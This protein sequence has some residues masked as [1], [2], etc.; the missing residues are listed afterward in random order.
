[1]DEIRQLIEGARQKLMA[2]EAKKPPLQL[3]ACLSCA[4]TF[5]ER[6]LRECD[7]PTLV[8]RD[9]ILAHYHD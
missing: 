6:A 5:I 8:P 7:C 4:M 9:P 3:A 1:M 2:I